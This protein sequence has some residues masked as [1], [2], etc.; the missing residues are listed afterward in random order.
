MFKHNRFERFGVITSVMLVFLVFIQAA[1]QS[2]ITVSR[3]QLDISIPEKAV[4]SLAADS[5]ANFQQVTLIYNVSRLSCQEG[6]ARRHMDFKPDDQVRLDWEL[7]FQRDGALLPG[8]ELAWQWELQDAAG[9]LFVTEP[10]TI[11]V[12]DQRH[13]WQSS[14]RGPVQVQWYQGDR[15]FGQRI[16]QTAFRGLGQLQRDLGV[17]Y[18][19]P[20][21][22]TVYP[23]MDELRE[24]LVE[25]Y[26]WT[27]AVALPEQGLILMAVS[28][29]DSGWIED[30]VPHELSHLV[31]LALTFN[32][33]GGIVPT[34]LEEGLA[35][36]A[37]G[38]I[39][40]QE[41]DSVLSALQAGSLPPLET[42]EGRFSQ[43]SDEAGQSYNQS[44]MVVAY[45]VDTFGPDKLGGLLAA[46]QS[47]IKIDK[48]L[49]S[50]Y[51][52]DTDGLDRVWRESLGFKVTEPAQAGATPT[53]TT[54]PTIALWTPVVQ[55]SPTSV[56]SPSPTDTQ[57]P[58]PTR[59]PA[60]TEIAQEL[61][62]SPP[63]T[64]IT[65]LAGEPVKNT[66]PCATGLMI[67]LPL[68]MLGVR[69]IKNYWGKKT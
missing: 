15:A 42:L 6:T 68:A 4:F 64:P 34:W 37:V 44:N 63:P 16:A 39:S 57:P 61:A 22:I 2:P 48:A 3:N 28:S 24:V 23:D 50:V 41:A 66:G 54:I 19:R 17:T 27:G 1:A 26:E 38:P 9:N 49:A 11:T 47:G 51:G 7:D 59:L 65:P 53:R 18:Q 5:R 60:P 69:Q 20:I 30:V 8:Q 25:T 58:S 12:Q 55:A 36:R 21:R 35:E 13:N 45:L 40:P 32:C 10:L 62:T 33:Q 67:L 29:E 31:L 52:F 14:S 43:Y 56:P 46:L